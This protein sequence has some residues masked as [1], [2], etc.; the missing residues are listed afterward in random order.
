MK[1]YTYIDIVFNIDRYIYKYPLIVIGIKSLIK[2]Y[3]NSHFNSII[4]R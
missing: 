4:F 3:Q 2:N 1:E